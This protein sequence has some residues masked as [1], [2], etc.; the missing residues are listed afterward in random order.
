[1]KVIFLGTSGTIPTPSR[2]SP[3]VA[4]KRKGEI[5][6]FDC[7]EGTQV[8]FFRA[9]LNLQKI[10]KIFISHLHGD[11][12]LG[13]PGII[14][15]SSLQG[16]SKP[17]AIYGP[18]GTISF[19]K[20]ITES[21]EHNSAFEIKVHDVGEGVIVDDEEYSIRCVDGDHAVPVL[22]YALIEKERPG[23]FHPEKARIL[24]IPEGPQWSQ[25]QA[26]KSINH[27]G[28]IIKP[29]E[30][31]GP[32]RAGRK[33]VYSGDTRPSQKILELSKGADLLIHDGTFDDTLREK[34]IEVGHS[35]VVEAA[36]LAKK[37]EVKRLV[38]SHISSRYQ[39]VSILKE[40]IANIFPAAQIAEDFLEIEIPL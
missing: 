8:Q 37:A 32:P 40:Q 11:H 34:A 18:G 1:M 16:R 15:T 29:S 17:M 3:S 10:T 4:V 24:K 2:G 26:G 31:L 14:M 25:L 12:V 6:L 7:G 36:H 20:A 33:L 21:L 38:L 35:T 13:I 5:L 30:V 23:K 9:K 27:E 19:M 28:R 39:D 22:A